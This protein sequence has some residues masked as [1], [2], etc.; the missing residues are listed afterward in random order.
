MS[1]QVCVLHFGNYT[2]LSRCCEIAMRQTSVNACCTRQGPARLTCTNKDCRY[3]GH[4]ASVPCSRRIGPATLSKSFAG[5]APA[6]GPYLLPLKTPPVAAWPMLPSVQSRN[7]AEIMKIRDLRP[8]S[9]P[10][11]VLSHPPKHC[12]RLRSHKKSVAP[13]SSAP[14]MF[15]AAKLR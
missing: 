13:P 3:S 6:I 15:S 7:H 14:D 1:S 8:S 12:F 9:F 11:R 5:E 2:I 10:S 4:Y